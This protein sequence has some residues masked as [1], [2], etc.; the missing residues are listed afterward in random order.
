MY[1]IGIV[2]AES[3]HA[4]VFSQLINTTGT[5]NA[6]VC[7][8]W[9]ENGQEQRASQFMSEY[10]ID[11]ILPSY[12]NMPEKVDMALI[13][14]RNGA[15]HF[16]QAKP[17]IDAKVPVWIDKPFALNSDDAKHICDYAKEKGS[18]II[19][20]STI[21]HSMEFISVKDSIEQE[22]INGVNYFS[23]S[24]CSS[25]GNPNGGISFYSIHLAELIYAIFGDNIE[26]IVANVCGKTVTVLLNYKN[27]T[28]ANLIMTDGGYDLTCSAI[29]GGG[30]Y[31]ARHIP[32]RD[33]YTQALLYMQSILDKKLSPPLADSLIVPIKII[34]TIEEA[35]LSGGKPVLYK[36]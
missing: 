18:V 2:G 8:I 29:G 12:E 1:K 27:S 6:H 11:E 14:T 3:T 16:K 34:E 17:F 19:G 26:S 25:I 15:N 10:G 31:M 4:K 22:F 35:V 30:R 36:K 13:V 5:I 7:C 20:G 24:Y 32:C 9:A 23:I 33:C 28:V 21:K